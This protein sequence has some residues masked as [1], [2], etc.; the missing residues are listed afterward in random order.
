VDECKPLVTG[1]EQKK[2]S[3][4]E[5]QEAIALFNKKPKKGIAAMQAL[6]RLGSSPPDIAEFLRDT[7]DLDKAGPHPLHNRRCQL[8]LTR[9]R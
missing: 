1:I 2:A 3:K 4:L 8:G 9:G 5:Y 7:P 6:G